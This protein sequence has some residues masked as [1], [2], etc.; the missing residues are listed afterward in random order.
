MT[1][2]IWNTIFGWIGVAG[3]IVI[4]CIVVGYFIPSLRLSMLAVGGAAIAVASAFTKGYTA[5]GKLEA[6]RKEEA[7]RRAQKE[8]AD[9]NSRP[10]TPRDA[11]KRMRDGGF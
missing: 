4:G 3:L 10:D 8:Y 11:V 5:R 1:D 6:K 7:V 2:F 9:I